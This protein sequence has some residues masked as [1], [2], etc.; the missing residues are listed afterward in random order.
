[1]RRNLVEN[2]GRAKDLKIPVLERK[3][4]IKWMPF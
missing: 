4:E 1:L 3:E 2:H